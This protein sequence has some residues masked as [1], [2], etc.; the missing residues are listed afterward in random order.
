MSAQN[1]DSIEIIEDVKGT[2]EN[3]VCSGRGICDTSTGECN[4]FTGYGSSDGKG[5]KG[6]FRDCG[7]LEPINGF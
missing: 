7:Y 4:C 6:T 3:S 5:G 1:V 2:K